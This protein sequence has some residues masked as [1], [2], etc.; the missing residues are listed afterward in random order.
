[1]RVRREPAALRVATIAH[2]P[3]AAPSPTPTGT[4]SAAPPPSAAMTIDPTG[5]Q[6]H[7]G[8]HAKNAAGHVRLGNHQHGTCEQ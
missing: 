4:A 1:M 2:P 5:D 3:A 8:G 7:A 6:R